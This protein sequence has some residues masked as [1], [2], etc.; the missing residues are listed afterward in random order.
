MSDARLTEALWLSIESTY[1]EIL[2]H[3]FLTG[4]TDATLARE[5]F[6]FYVVQDSLYL[7]SFARVLATLAGRTDEPLDTAMLARHASNAI[8]VEQSLHAGFRAELGIS[9]DEVDSTPMAP[10]CRAY[11]SHL[12]SCAYGGTFLEGVAAVLPCYWI[13]WQVGK[14]LLQHGSPDEQY[15][16]WIQTYAGDQF[17]AVVREVLA[18]TDRLDDDLAEAERARAHDRFA[19]AA[20]YE[21][22][23]WEMAYRR[24]QW[25]PI[26][27]DRVRRN[28]RT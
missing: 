18:L 22:M 17:A 25:P 24:E 1:R 6:T 3:P 21:W 14:E 28:E 16:R 11:A 5:S 2:V 27:D 26:G 13:Y 12:E 15:D 19:T 23:F 20:R 8:A 4:L 10:T 9:D 7:R